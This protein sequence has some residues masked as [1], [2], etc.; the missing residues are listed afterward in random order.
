MNKILCIG[1]G[2]IGQ[3]HSEILT[4]MGHKVVFRDKIAARNTEI[5][6]DYVYD[7]ALICTPAGVRDIVP[8]YRGAAP[9][10]V[11]KPMGKVPQG[12]NIQVGFC[13]YWLPSLAKYVH[14]L[15]YE[16]I[17]SLTLI[18]GQKIEEWHTEPYQHRTHGIP[19]KGGVVLDSLPH[20]LFIARWILGEMNVVGSVTGHLS[21]L[22]IGPEDVAAVLLKSAGGV[23]CY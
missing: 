16:R 21:G 19:G 20:S 4:E 15:S 12:V 5:D 7:A 8:M 2:S 10:F 6:M 17:Y 1:A 22:D 3:K 18:A 9:L 11:E 14:S 13:Y 23:P